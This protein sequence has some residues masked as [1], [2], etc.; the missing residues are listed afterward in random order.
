MPVWLACFCAIT[1]ARSSAHFF[2]FCSTSYRRLGLR[3]RGGR[4]VDVS[5]RVRRLAAQT[6]R[7]KDV[8]K[9]AAVCR[10]PRMLSTSAATC[11]VAVAVRAMIGVC[12]KLCRS[13][14]SSL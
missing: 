5:W 10:M 13:L 3:R 1:L 2:F 12:G 8:L 7:L 14:Q 4:V 11:L 6:C 9:Q